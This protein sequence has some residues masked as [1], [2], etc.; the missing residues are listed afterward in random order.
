MLSGRNEAENQMQPPLF[1]ADHTSLK[2]CDDV[3]VI[4]H[5]RA[6]VK[7]DMWYVPLHFWHLVWQ[8]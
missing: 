5:E 2:A 1:C 4:R 6:S 8:G 7:A 3:Q